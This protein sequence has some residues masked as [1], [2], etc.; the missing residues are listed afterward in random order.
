L[1]SVTR[2]GINFTQPLVVI[3]S[4]F[5][6]ADNGTGSVN[7]VEIYYDK[8]LPLIPDSITLYWPL[9]S[10]STMQT[11]SG[12]QLG[13]SPDSMHLTI[14]L[15]APFPPGLTYA[16]SADKLG[17]SYNRPNTA[18][19]VSA[20][21]TNFA[22]TERVGPLIMSAQV[23]ERLSP[24]A[25]TD[26]MYVTFSEPIKAASLTGNALILIK[27]G[28]PSELSISS[29][30]SISGA[31]FKLTVVSTAFPPQLGDSLK[32]DAAGSIT[33]TL[34]NKPNAL[35]RPVVITQKPIPAAIVSAWYLDKNADGVVDAV[36]IKFAKSVSLSDLLIKLTWGDFS[37]ATT[38]TL[39]TWRFSYFGSDSWGVEIN[40]T[41]AFTGA[42]NSIAADSIK[43]SGH[44]TATVGFQSMPEEPTEG[45]TVTDSAAPVILWAKYLPDSLKNGQTKPIDKVVVGFS[46]PINSITATSPF[47]FSAKKTNAPYTITFNVP[48]KGDTLYVNQ[49][50]GVVFPVT[51]DSVWINPAAG[52]SDAGSITQNNP[53]NRRVAL[54]VAPIPYSPPQ[55]SIV[56]NPFTINGTVID[57]AGVTATGTI[58]EISPP[59]QLAGL[60]TFSATIKI[61]DILGNTVVKDVAFTPNSNGILYFKWDGRNFNS[62]F[63]G[64]GAYIAIISLADSN[65][66][67]STTK[68]TIG[69]KR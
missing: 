25:G 52:I 67:S 44:M 3:D 9:K 15:T 56:K 29:A 46:E 45:T 13:L 18:P 32:I 28:A 41:G 4:A 68:L 1:S 26:T 43:T 12:S 50:Q 66:K 49:I 35:N 61:Y 57:A 20:S 58:I 16:T 33:D 8:K 69:V 34:S 21:A 55:I 10:T 54:F 39:K 36:R 23:V 38:D 51:G 65:G 6:Y 22:I 48:N 59:K 27:N 63:V 40:D 19:G 2:S 14:N 37:P 30:V 7:R 62:R 5:Y 11:V 42:S 47:N 31:R 64:S 24:T 17:I 53:S 60:I